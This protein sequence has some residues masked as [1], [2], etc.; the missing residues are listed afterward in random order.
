MKK[1]HRNYCTAVNGFEALKTFQVNPE[2]FCCVLM[3]N[4]VQPPATEKLRLMSM[5]DINMPIMDGLESTRLI[6][7]FERENHLKP[8]TIIAITGLASDSARDEAFASGLNVFLTRPVSLGQLVPVLKERVF[9]EAKVGI[10][11]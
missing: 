2:R 8:V 5:P 3:G 4:Y 11:L 1:L 6:R 9:E 7:K 10:E